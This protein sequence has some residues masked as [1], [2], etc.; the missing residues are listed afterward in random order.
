MTEPVELEKRLELLQGISIFFTLPDRDMRRL[1]RKL[2]PRHVGRGEDVVKQGEVADRMHI[3][4]SGRCE[5]R[6]TWAPHHSV[7]VAVLGPGDFFGLSA[8][9]GGTPQAASVTSIEPCEFLELLIDD[10]D[11]VLTEDSPVRAEVD[12]LVEQRR[13]TIE[14]LVERAHQMSASHDGRIIAVYSV[15]GGAGKT[16]LAVNLA[17]ALGLRNRGESLLLDLGLPYNH[18]ALTANLVPTGSLAA[19]ERASDGE[20]EEMLLSACMHHPTGMMLLP[21]ALRVEQSELITPELVDR[22]L[23]ALMRTFP[24]LVVDLGVAMSEA[25]L[26][27][28]ERAHRIILVITPELTSLKDTKE[29]MELFRT[30]LNIPIG[31]VTL[32]LN[33]PR[34]TSIVDRN[35]IERSLERAVDVELDHDGYRCDRAAVTGELLVS[36]FPTSPLAKKLK[37]LAAA[38][39]TE[40]RSKPAA[41]PVVEEVAP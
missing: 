36:A 3:I 2:Q 14:H 7:T 38:L 11:G 31:S 13:A 22:S 15:K 10:I 17:A 12:R 37:A 26:M 9:K 34:A 4:V 27:V 30:V 16:T 1:A 18:A 40:H 28:L 33:R 19:N 25:A 29:L 6:E 41:A 5:V 35:D 39:E 32:V 24:Y 21:G 8:M 23:T 20:L